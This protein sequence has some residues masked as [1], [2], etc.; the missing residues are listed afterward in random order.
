MSSS[1]SVEKG[2]VI[3]LSH[4]LLQV[5]DLN[6]AEM[7]Y[8]GLL[9]LTVRARS[10]FGGNR[11]L[12][13]TLEGIGMTTLPVP[14]EGPLPLEKRNVE[15]IALWVKGMDAL[16]AK[17]E[18]AGF[19]VDGPKRNEYGLSMSVRDPDGNRVECIERLST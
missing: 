6:A 7:F 12:I 18:Q 5:H 9:G 17:M 2:E 13:S 15:H 11:P 19:H 4:L 8:C 3:G 16:V 1:D 10:T 14:E